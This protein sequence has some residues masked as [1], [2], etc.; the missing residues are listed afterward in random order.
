MTT[1][2]DSEDFSPALRATMVNDLRAMGAITSDRVA[3]AVS[4]VPRHRFV[5]DQP[6]EAVY[7]ADHAVVIKRDDQGT[8]TSSLSSAH[9]QSVMLEQAEITPGMRVLEIGSGGYNAAL[10]AELVGDDGAVVS[11]DIDPQI[12]D[13]ARACLNSVGYERVKVVVGDA[14]HGVPGEDAFDRIIVTAGAWDIPPAWRTQLAP[15]GRLVVP[16]RLKGITR[17]IAFETEGE[18]LTSVSYRLSGFVPM[19]GDG[20]HHERVYPVG[21]HGSWGLRTDDDTFDIAASELRA[22]LERPRL[23]QPSGTVFDLPDELELF[24]LASHPQ[25]MMLHARPTLI[26]QRAFAAS[27]GRGVPALVRGGSFAYRTKRENADVG[28]FETVV[29]AHGPAAEQVAAEYLGL[30]RCW[31]RDH[32]RRGAATIRYIPVGHLAPTD[33]AISKRHGT[34]A[35]T[36]H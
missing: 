18:E 31:A 15:A 30:L 10:I 12:A 29:I 34:V 13:R 2:R 5:P 21:D 22:A 24:L 16:L 11:V 28:G 8:A 6:L 3:H 26:E 33:G 1:V 14:E 7:A 27:A 25:M 9:I 20:Q 17:S 19:Q 35:I 36:W 4:T 23:E 32:R